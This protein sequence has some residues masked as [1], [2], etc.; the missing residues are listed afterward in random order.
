[1]YCIFCGSQNL[2]EID[3][4]Y[5]DYEKVKIGGTYCCNNCQNEFSIRYNP[6]KFVYNDLA[7]EK[8]V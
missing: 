2:L 3:A 7:L 4:A 8:I 1:M 6:L 5:G